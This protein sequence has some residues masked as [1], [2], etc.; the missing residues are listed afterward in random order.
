MYK[1]IT[2]SFI[3]T[4]IFLCPL[5]SLANEKS[6]DEIITRALTGQNMIFARQY[7]NAIKIFE[8]L[9]RDFPESPAGDF[10]L[11]A[12]TE[13]RMLEREDFHLENEFLA[14]SKRGAEKVSEVTAAARPGVWDLFLA[15]SLMGIDGFFYARKGKWWDAYTVG[16][17][18]RQLFR[19]VKEIDPTF[20]DADFG[21]GM[22]IF[23]R[24]VY[25]RDLWFLRMFPDRRAEGIA[26]VQNVAENGRFAK[27]LARVNLAVMYFE[28]KRYDESQKIL[29][30]YLAR[31]P[32]NVILRMILGKLFIIQKHYGE[33]LAQFKKVLTIE[34]AVKKARYFSG[35]SMVLMN[36][37]KIFGAAEKE[38]RGFIEVE[39]SKHWKASAHFWLGKL[40]EA[41]GDVAAARAEYEEALRLNPKVDMASQRIRALGSGL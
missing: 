22:Y 25:T 5:F 26:I 11:M 33:A 14:Y 40:D 36:D 20:V 23:W 9:N 24:S 29:N 19:H 31:Y 15:G 1:K 28:E 21:L 18:S 7:D 30:D 27:D 6:N 37:P 17:K 8:G 34:P 4:A 39:G 32:D 16:T 38:L 3:L 2:Q 35:I 10:G 13:M 12:T 41:R